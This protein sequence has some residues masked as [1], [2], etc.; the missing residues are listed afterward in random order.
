MA[1]ENPTDEDQK[2]E[3]PTE[4]R[5]EKAFEEGRIAYSRELVHWAVLA[6]AAALLLWLIPYSMSS[7]MKMTASVFENCGD[8]LF[9]GRQSQTHIRIFWEV[10]KDT[11]LLLPL[12]VVVLAIGFS[13]TK[14]NFTLSQIQPKLERISPAA[15][16]KRVLGKQAIVEF[17]KNLLKI[18][19][20]A[21]VMFWAIKGYGDQILLWSTIS[22][23]DGL[24]VLRDIFSSLFIA[25]LSILGLIAGL[26]YAY[27]RFTFWKSMKMSRQEIKDEH[28]EQEGNPQVKAKLREMR[29]HRVR[30]RMGAKVK[31]ATVVVTNPTHYAIAIHWDEAVMDAPRVVAKG[32]DFLAEQIRNI[33]KE[34]N[35]PIVENPPLARSLYEKVKIDQEI[36]PEHYRA[37]AEVIK[38]ITELA[39]RRF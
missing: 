29:M 15:G 19:V 8:E 13:Q 25:A 31:T 35:I 10:L 6:S 16:L 7:F 2:T 9:T 34:N 30:E 4:R 32:V 11:I 38:F 1:D 21:A 23:K 22:L 36:E 20:V 37:V 3:E 17:L 14:L 26:D 12:V 39:Q 28:K 27:Q 24:S 5:L 33:A 18:A